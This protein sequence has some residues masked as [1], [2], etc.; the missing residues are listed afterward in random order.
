LQAFS[1]DNRPNW[2]WDEGRKTTRI[3]CK[4]D[5]ETPVKRSGSRGIDVEAAVDF[6]NILFDLGQATLKPESLRQIAEIGAALA[7]FRDVRVSVNG[8]TD[9]QG[10]Q[11]VTDPAENLRRNL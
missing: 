5:E 2:D 7:E 10:F 4:K 9:K 3:A 8:H 11:G 6:P 1:L